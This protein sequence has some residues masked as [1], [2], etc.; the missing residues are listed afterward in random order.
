M[1]ISESFDEFSVEMGDYEVKKT[2]KFDRMWRTEQGGSVSSCVNLYNGLLYFTSANYN[3][4]CVRPENG[5]LVWKFKTE[6]VMVECRPMIEDGI[7]YI[8]NYDRNVYALDAGNGS[9]VWKFTTSDKIASSAVVSDGMVFFGGKDQ[10][11]YA[12][13]AKTGCLIWKHKTF[14][15][16]ISEP[17]V[18]GE[19][20]FV[21]SYDHFLY[22]FEKRSGRLLWKFETQGEIHNTNAFAHRDGI[23]YFGSFD[24]YTRALDIRTG[25]LLWKTKCGN[26][27]IGVS[28]VLHENIIL[29]A[30]RGGQLFAL[31]MKGHVL[32]KYN[33]SEEDVMGIPCV[34]KGLLYL[35]SAGDYCMHCF[36]LDGKELWRYKTE[37]IVYNRSVMVGAHLIFG[38]WDCNLYCIDVNT[39]QVVWKFRAPGSPAYVPPPFEGFEL[40]IKLKESDLD[41]RP[42]SEGGNERFSEEGLDTYKSKVTYRMSTQYASKG[43]YQVDSDEEAF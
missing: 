35:P 7:L 38:S 5:E 12:V 4:Y 8:S 41:E 39:R 28:P 26:Y 3:V 6:G 11:V 40:E 31:D 42:R 23:I 13:G 29:Q 17:L 14:D 30:T 37:G 33:G 27:G 19:Q 10:N 18:V 20:L 16:I 36:S 32:W 15:C 9:L 21:G 34:H 2:G 43:K 22:C 24:N 1:E 25:R